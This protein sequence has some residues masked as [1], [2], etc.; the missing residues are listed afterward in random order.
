MTGWH[1]PGQLPWTSF[2]AGPRCPGRRSDR[3]PGEGREWRYDRRAIE[4]REKREREKERVASGVR[5]TESNRKKIERGVGFR[6][7][8]GGASVAAAGGQSE[9]EGVG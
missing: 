3:A 6:W 4:K 9:A 1:F 7:C 8:E 5:T 2:R